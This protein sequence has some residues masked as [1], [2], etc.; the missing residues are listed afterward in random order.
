MCFEDSRVLSLSEVE[1]LILL[2]GDWLRLRV[3]LGRE[4]EWSKRWNLRPVAT[5]LPDNIVGNG[6]DRT[7]PYRLVS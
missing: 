7:V 4:L 2:L 5:A 6:S 3:R 1:R